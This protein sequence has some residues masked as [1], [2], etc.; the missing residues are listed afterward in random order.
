MKDW[1]NV[2]WGDC[3][4]CDAKLKLAAGDLVRCT[5]CDFHMNAAKFFARVPK[6]RIGHWSVKHRHFTEEDIVDHALG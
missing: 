2:F 3:P 6:D 1:C 5:E 4:K